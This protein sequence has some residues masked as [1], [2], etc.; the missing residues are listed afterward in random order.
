MSRIKEEQLTDE[1]A[2]KFLTFVPVIPGV[3]MVIKIFE[4]EGCSQKPESPAPYT[5]SSA[6]MKAIFDNLTLGAGRRAELECNIDSPIHDEV[7]SI[8][9]SVKS[10]R[11]N[12]Q[13]HVTNWAE[14]Q[15]ED[16]EIGAAM[17]WCRLDRKKSELPTTIEVQVLPRPTQEHSHREK[18]VEK[19][20]P[21]DPVWR[22]VVPQI[23]A[24]I[25]S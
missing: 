2:D 17:D 7:D 8:E 11:L 10:A 25:P 20:R 1:E 23:H 5:M 4:E 12:S 15:Q 13:M 6:A 14:A 24:K 3:E 16:P 22:T 9:V 21:A 18:P 19:C